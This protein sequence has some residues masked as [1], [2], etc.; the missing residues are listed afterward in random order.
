MGK[1]QVVP[2]DSKDDGPEDLMVSDLIHPF[3]IPIT[4]VSP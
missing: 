4:I 1:F 2:Y 3:I